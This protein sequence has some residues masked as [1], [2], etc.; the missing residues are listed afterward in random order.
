M[1]IFA[2]LQGSLDKPFGASSP[3]LYK[4]NWSVYEHNLENTYKSN[5]FRKS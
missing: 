5:K 1:Y 2:P 3:D 4:H